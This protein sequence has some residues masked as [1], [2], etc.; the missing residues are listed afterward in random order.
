MRICPA[1]SWRAVAS[2]MH[3]APTNF[4]RFRTPESRHRKLAEVPA[5][6]LRLFR[7]ERVGVSPAAMGAGAFATDATRALGFKRSVAPLGR[8]H[9]SLPAGGRPRL[10]AGVR[11]PS[12][13]EPL[14]TALAQS[15]ADEKERR[16]GI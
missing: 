10:P 5:A 9:R 6:G 13:R 1:V 3:V 14:R 2:A 4:E 12:E 16:I 15:A 11:K 7:E 8:H